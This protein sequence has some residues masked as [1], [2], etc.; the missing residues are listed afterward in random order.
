M[1]EVNFLAEDIFKSFSNVFILKIEDIFLRCLKN[2]KY[3]YLL[4]SSQSELNT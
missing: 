2:G 1:C 3:I 4:V